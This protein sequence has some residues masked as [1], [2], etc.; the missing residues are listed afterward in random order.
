M[1]STSQSSYNHY[2]NVGENIMMPFNYLSLM[3]RSVIKTSCHLFITAI[4]HALVVHED[5]HRGIIL[6]TFILVLEHQH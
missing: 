4:E 1:R 6:E 2:V 3:T 5:S